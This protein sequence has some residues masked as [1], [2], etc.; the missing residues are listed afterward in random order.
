MI[1]IK[2]GTEPCELLA[3]KQLPNAM[4][5]GPNFTPVKET[6]RESLLAEQGYICAYCM[7]RIQ[8]DG[9]KMKIEHWQSQSEFSSLQLDFK[10]MLAVCLGNPGASYKNTHCDTHRGKTRLH[11]NPSTI[12][13]PIDSLIQYSSN[14]QITSK[15]LLIEEDIST[16]NLNQVRLTSNRKEVIDMI[17]LHLGKEEGRR[18]IPE[19]KKLLEKW[20]SRDS[21][22]MLKPYCGVAIFYIKKKL[23]GRIQ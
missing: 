13:T 7:Q 10:N 15:N 8:N 6:I 2:K 18:T 9:L 5:D 23:K 12:S 17:S 1:T 19:L 14:G 22:N 20:E 4:Y 3:Y 11:Y 16:L 21:N